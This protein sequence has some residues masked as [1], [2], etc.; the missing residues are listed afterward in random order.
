LNYN[1]KFEKASK[2]KTE[3]QTYGTPPIFP[4]TEEIIKG[5]F[6]TKV[7]QY[8]IL[9]EMGIPV[10]DIPKFTDPVYYTNYFSQKALMNLKKLGISV[11]WRRTFISSENQYF[12]QFINWQFTKLKEKNLVFLGNRYSIIST[13]YEQPCLDMDRSIGEGVV[14]FVYFL[15]KSKFVVLPD[16]LSEFDGKF[17]IYVAVITESPETLVFIF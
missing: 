17:D 14:P 4:K 5:K 2:I 6:K 15:I 7:Y 3:L 1:K 12:D 10:H 8:N 13:I 11:D 9:K 16:I